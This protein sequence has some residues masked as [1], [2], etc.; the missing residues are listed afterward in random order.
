MDGGFLNR[1]AALAE[2]V[3]VDDEDLA[4]ILV[5]KLL[6]AHAAD[7]GVGAEPLLVDAVDQIV[8]VIFREAELGPQDDVQPHLVAP[9][10][11]GMI[12]AEIVVADQVP[13][14]LRVDAGEVFGVEVVRDHQAGEPVAEIAV[15]HVGGVKVAAAA[16]FGGVGVG[17]VAVAVHRKNSLFHDEGESLL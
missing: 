10:L 12:A 1:G 3:G 7:I 11:G 2:G 16:G 6:G 17:V 5:E 8:V 15:H 4:V 9:A 13:V 14:V